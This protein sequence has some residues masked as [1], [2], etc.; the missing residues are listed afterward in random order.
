MDSS[1]PAPSSEN[2]RLRVVVIKDG[3]P[4][5]QFCAP[6]TFRIGNL[7]TELARRGHDTVWISSTF[8]HNEKEFYAQEETVEE[9]QEGYEMRFLQA[10]SYRSNISF[11]RW[12]HH[13][14]LAWRV[15]RVL[16]ERPRPDVVVCCIPI[17]EVASVCRAFCKKQGVPLVLDIQDPWPQIFVDYAP[18]PLKPLVRAALTPYF[19]NA[20][21]LF[22]T[23]DSLVSVSHGFLSWAQ[24]LGRRDARRRSWDRVVYIGGHRSIAEIEPDPL[25][26]TSG[27]RTLYMGAFN[28]AY[29]LEPLARMLEVQAARG[30]DHHMFVLGHSGKRYLRLRERLEGL[31]NVTFTGWIPREQV[32]AIAQTCHLGWLPLDVGNEGYAPNKL[33]EYPALGLPVGAR[34]QGEAGRLVE[35]HGIGF[36]HDGDGEALADFVAGLRPGEGLLEGWRAR[37]AIFSQRVGDA[38]ICAGQF[39]DQVERIAAYRG[40]D[41]IGSDR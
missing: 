17:L 10:G 1:S 18:R 23:A 9:R 4:L 6:W 27:L 22:G 35:E 34:R 5:P 21:H 14:R 19:W 41:A 33:F 16:Q 29:D 11:G 2:R 38:R 30:D 7:C 20:A 15:S 37:C 26:P 39:A 31:P 8:R 13:A 12:K 40:R 32:Y 24:R 28:G 36:Q 3:E 25:R